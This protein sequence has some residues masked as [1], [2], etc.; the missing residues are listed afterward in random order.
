MFGWDEC[1]LIPCFSEYLFLRIAFALH[2]DV[3]LRQG[4][5]KNGVEVQ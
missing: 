1:G 5:A 3:L 2:A 4:K